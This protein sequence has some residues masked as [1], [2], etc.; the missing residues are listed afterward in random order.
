MR[1]R[2]FAID[3]LE[4]GSLVEPPVAAIVVLRQFAFANDVGGVRNQPAGGLAAPACI[5]QAAAQVI[6]VGNEKI[7]QKHGGFVAVEV[8]D[9]GAPAADFGAVEDVIVYQRGHV[10]H[11]HHRRERDVVISD[12]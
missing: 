8:I 4:I 7:A 9:R 2:R 6:G 1:G 11:F 5:V 10:D 12:S 3:N